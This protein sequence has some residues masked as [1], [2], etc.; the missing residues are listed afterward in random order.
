MVIII[1]IWIRWQTQ[2]NMI[3]IAIIEFQYS[4]YNKIRYQPHM[5]EIIHYLH[6]IPCSRCYQ[7]RASTSRFYEMLISLPAEVTMAWKKSY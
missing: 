2:S 7:I 3:N 1:L 6:V 5:Q 4:F